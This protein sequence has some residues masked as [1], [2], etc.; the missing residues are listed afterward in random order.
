MTYVKKVQIFTADRAKVLE[1]SIN[2][3]ILKEME[4]GFYIIDIQYQATCT[5]HDHAVYSCMVFYSEPV[6]EW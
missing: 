6:E 5:R 4:R 2:S 3:F 1:Q